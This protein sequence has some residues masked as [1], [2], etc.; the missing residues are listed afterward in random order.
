M[1]TVFI[2][3]VVFFILALMLISIVILS[4]FISQKYPNS[5][6]DKFIK[7]HIIDNYDGDDF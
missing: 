6:M 1:K 7:R 2:I 5:R 3:Y 4:Y